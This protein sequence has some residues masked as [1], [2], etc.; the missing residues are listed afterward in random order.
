MTENRLSDY[1]GHIRQAVVD[2]GAYIE[3]MSKADF[4]D[5]KRTQQAVIMNLIV[6]G[7]AATK[8]LQD[9]GEQ[10]CKTAEH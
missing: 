4:F 6:I 2:V 10:C 1:L 9:H 5:D 3:G 8:I 7:E